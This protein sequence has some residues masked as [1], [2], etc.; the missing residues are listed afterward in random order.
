MN[1]NVVLRCFTDNNKS[2]IQKYNIISRVD[3]IK[4]R[5]KKKLF[6]ITNKDSSIII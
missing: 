4:N 1:K 3:K 2:N 6:N 5:L